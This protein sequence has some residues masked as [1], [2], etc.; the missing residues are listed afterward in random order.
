MKENSKLVCGPDESL[1]KLFKIFYVWSKTVK[2]LDHEPRR[3]GRKVSHSPDH[4]RLQTISY[5]ERREHGYD[6]GFRRL[7]TK[8]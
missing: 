7:V 3:Q 1:I 2:K 5:F 4:F 8:G 6:V